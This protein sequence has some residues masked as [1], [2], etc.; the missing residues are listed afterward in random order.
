LNEIIEKIDKASHI[1]LISHINPDAD[2]IGS[3][4][5]M[6][7]FL[8][9]NHKKVSWFCKS[10][11]ISNKLSFMPWFENIKATFPASAD[12]A[13]S[14]DC[15]DKKRLGVD[16][17]CDLINIDHHDTNSNYGDINLV[18][19][20]AI[21]TTEILYSFFKENGAKINKKMATALYAGLLDDSDSFTS[22]ST[23]GTTFALAKELIEQGA[24][25]KLCV[26]NIIK[27]HSLAAI[28]LKAVMFKNMSL[29]C[30]ARVAFF[31]V[32]DEDMRSTGAFSWE[33]EA[34]LEESLNIVHVEVAILLRQN[35]DFS[36]KGSLRSNLEF[37]CAKIASNFGGGGHMQRA[38]FEIESGLSLNEAREIVFSL[39]KK[40][41][42]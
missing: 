39:I 10:E 12:L 14:L 9:Q 24:D 37:D 31:C 15:A 36:I 20:D 23:S 34:A 18:K 40:E 19:T 28:R 17:E 21:S 29:E 4:S 22:D 27:S 30:G 3:A 1:V 6:Y 25:Y 35:S 13:I 42:V 7:T 11:T 32:S 5:T 8:L 33:C 38:G 16:V 2:S 26:K 41:I